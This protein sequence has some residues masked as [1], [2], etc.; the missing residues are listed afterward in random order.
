MAKRGHE[1]NLASGVMFSPAQ[2]NAR[3][4]KMRI[5]LLI[6][7][8][9]QYCE[10]KGI[11]ARHTKQPSLVHEFNFFKDG[12]HLG[13]RST[14]ELDVNK[15]GHR[16]MAGRMLEGVLGEELFSWNDLPL[17]PEP[18]ER[19]RRDTV[20]APPETSYRER[21]DTTPP[22][23]ASAPEAPVE[24]PVATGFSADWTIRQLRAWAREKETPVPV[25][26][27]RKGDIIQWLANEHP[28]GS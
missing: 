2:E 5:K 9:I 25:S 1:I 21:I 16:T 13:R 23:A 17:Q 8:I 20:G 26:I 12:S 4:Q 7:T 6:D 3:M 28:D 18:T 14:N 10:D 15:I 22:K 19:A 11:E 24:V 27:T